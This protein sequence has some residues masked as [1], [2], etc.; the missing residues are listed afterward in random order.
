MIEETA[1]QLARPAGVLLRRLLDPPLTDRVLRLLG[2][3]GSVFD[4][5]LHNTVNATIVR[6][7]EKVNVIPSEAT[8]EMDGRLLPGFTARDM[9]REVGD[10]LCP[11][12]EIEVMRYDPGPPEAD[13]GRHAVRSR[14][15]VPGARRYS[16]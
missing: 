6:G 14:R 8:V 16:R 10:L 11:D 4:P 7:G 3:R 1:A 12:A 13:L 2:E 15:G 9:V 5:L